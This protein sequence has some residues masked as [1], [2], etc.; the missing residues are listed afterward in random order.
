MHR[1][2]LQLQVI[3]ELRFVPIKTVDQQ[4]VLCLHRARQGFVKVRT[5]QA[6]QIRRLL[7]E[8][9]L[10][11]PQGITNVLRRAPQLSDGAADLP[12]SLRQVIAWPFENMK[13]VDRQVKEFEARIKAWHQGSELSR[14]LEKA[15]APWRRVR[16]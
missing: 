2:S 11:L 5:A 8:F 14:K 12:A 1:L 3:E 9:G 15:L 6:N 10:A 16:C 4:S 13:V 7:T